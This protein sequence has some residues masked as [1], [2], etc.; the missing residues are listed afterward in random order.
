MFD[1]LK[2]FKILS[3]KR[4]ERLHQQPSITSTNLTK[5]ELKMSKE[6]LTKGD[7][8]SQQ[9]KEIKVRFFSQKLTEDD[10]RILDLFYTGEGKPRNGKE[11]FAIEDMEGYVFSHQSKQMDIWFEQGDMLEFAHSNSAAP[12]QIL[13]SSLFAPIAR[14]KRKAMTDHLVC[15]FEDFKVT[16]SGVQLDQADNDVL[17][18]LIELISEL[19][20]TDAIKKILDEDGN[21][22]YTQI[23]ASTNGFLKRIGKQSNKTTRVWLRQSLIRLSG[24]ISVIADNESSYNSPIVGGSW[25]N[26]NYTFTA[27]INYRYIRLFGNDNHTY[28]NLKQRQKLGRK[29]FA[30]WLHGFVSTHSGTSSYS[31]EKLMDLSGS[32]ARNIKDFK[33]DT[34]TPAFDALVEVGAIKEYKIK[35]YL[36]TWTRG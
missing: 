24:T 2:R 8:T 25:F 30:K 19:K 9:A 5:T 29:G 26:E 11:Q 15:N 7:I 36:Y 16:Y 14:G 22:R 17:L 31:M 27:S 23:T 6:N 12:K 21:Q 33:R 13:R 20:D 1:F 4:N 18:G 3:R 35:A 32:T 34:C 10:Y 28:I